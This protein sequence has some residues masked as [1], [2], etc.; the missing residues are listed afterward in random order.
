M[1]WQNRA[2]RLTED[3]C[4]EETLN[5]YPN[6]RKQFCINHN[7]GEIFT[8]KYF[9]QVEPESGTFYKFQI[10][11]DAVGPFTRSSE[12]ISPHSVDIYSNCDHLKNIY[13]TMSGTCSQEKLVI[14]IGDQLELKSHLSISFNVNGIDLAYITALKV[15]FS[16]AAGN[17]IT[18]EIGDM[19]TF[20]IS[21]ENFNTKASLVYL[22]SKSIHISYV[23]A[24]ARVS[25]GGTFRISAEKTPVNSTLTQKINLYPAMLKIIFMERKDYC[26]SS[27]SSSCNISLANEYYQQLVKNQE[28]CINID[29]QNFYA[30]FGYCKGAYK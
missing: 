22:S 20:D 4:S 5:F 23:Q 16:R 19:V 3:D 27:A 14:T 12:A 18:F 11:Y 25:K 26:L 29:E 21:N 30:K 10:R 15:D 8:T 17:G 7:T 6:P 13:D 9:S 1:T 2:K 28:E 24:P